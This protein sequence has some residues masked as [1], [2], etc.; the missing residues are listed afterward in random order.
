MTDDPRQGLFRLIRDYGERLV[1]DPRRLEALLR[2][3]CPQWDWK[4]RVLVDALKERVP[5]ELTSASSS[6]LVLVKSEQL[7]RR[8]EV[9]LALTQEA[10]RWAVDSWALAI[11]VVTSPP[12][13]QNPTSK[14]SRGPNHYAELRAAQRPSPPAQVPPEFAREGVETPPPPP[15]PPPTPP[16]HRRTWWL[17]LGAFALIVLGLGLLSSLQ[18]QAPPH[19]FKGPDG[20]WHPEDGYVWVASPH[21][22]SD[23]K[24]RW[25][26][27]QPSN[28]YLHIETSET[29]GKWRP[30]DGY[31]WAAYPPVLG[32]TG[33]KWTP[34]LASNKYFHVEA[35][36]PEEQWR[37]ADGYTWV[38]YPHA[39]GD[40]GVKWTPRRPSARYPHVLAG[41]LEDRWYPADG[42]TWMDNPPSAPGHMR[43]KWTPGRPSNENPNIVSS[44]TEGNWH[45][46]RGYTWQNPSDPKDYRV[47]PIEPANPTPPPAPEAQK[48]ET[49]GAF[50]QGLADRRMWEQWFASLTGE[51]LDGAFY[52]SGQRSLPSPGSCYSQGYTRQIFV[53]GCL[54]AKQRLD[55]TDK[56]RNSEPGYKAGWNSYPEPVPGPSSPGSPSTSTPSPVRWYPGMDAPGNDLGGPDGWLR[57]VA[58]PDDCMR[59]CLEDRACVG[60]TYNIRHSACFPKGGIAALVPTDVPATSG[61]ITDRSEP[62]PTSALTPHVQRYLDMDAPGGDRGERIYGVSNGSCESTCLA[63]RGCVGYT[64]NPKMRMCALKTFIGGLVPSSD[65][66]L[67]GIVEGRNVSAH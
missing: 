7:A 10:A 42:Y 41:E 12:P 4:P 22:P 20:E 31:T 64:Y 37:P 30:T 56:R 3:L 52:W 26:V 13:T 32:S 46:G 14:E 6:A 66:A 25:A 18:S 5:Q 62:P 44:E 27:G 17:W 11:G 35:D 19:V 43:V 29:E 38:V 24:V 63:D 53:D 21:V 48:P 67:T 55:P 9:D 39:P 2:D 33:V 16:P 1:E 58:N 65:A 49:S 23:L 51:Y 36:E 54:A 28:R 15:S 8:L 45:P 59:K 57:D 50:Q 60:V 34:G 40:M 47:K 61:I